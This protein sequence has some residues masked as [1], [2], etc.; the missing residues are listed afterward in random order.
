MLPNGTYS[1][2]YKTVTADSIAGQK[3]L[4]EACTVHMRR[5]YNVQLSNNRSPHHRVHGNLQ[6]EHYPSSENQTPSIL[7]LHVYNASS[8]RISILGMEIIWELCV[9]S[10]LTTVYLLQLWEL[11]LN[12]KHTMYLYIYT[13]HAA[14]GQF[15]STSL[16]SNISLFDS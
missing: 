15:Y 16:A 4:H 14:L 1:T 12:R 6:F 7:I 5:P 9:A 11:W 8:F 3:I 13:L 2:A 10:S